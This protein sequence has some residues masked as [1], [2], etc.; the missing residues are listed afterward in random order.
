MFNFYAALLIEWPPPKH[1]T[2][3]DFIFVWINPCFWLWLSWKLDCDSCLNGKFEL[4]LTLDPLDPFDHLD[5]LDR[6][7]SLDLLNSTDALLCASKWGT[8][9]LS[10]TTLRLVGGVG[11]SIIVL[12]NVIILFSEGCCP[13][14]C[15]GV[16]PKVCY[17]RASL[18]GLRGAFGLLTF[19][20]DSGWE[21]LYSSAVS[22][23]A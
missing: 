10:C 21:S 22:C 2:E 3:Y 9:L 14:V 1:A 18:S 11:F 7:K 12:T 16:C 15:P 6:R 23:R 20:S 17:A 8:T 13:G 4:L 5:P 19:L